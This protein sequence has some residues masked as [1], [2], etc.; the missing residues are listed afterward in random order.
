M[1]RSITVVVLCVALQLPGC[2]TNLGPRAITQTNFSYN[3]AISRSWNEQFVLN[4][5]RLRYR[6]TA[7]FLEVG[8]ILAQYELR[9]NADAT[10]TIIEGAGNVVGLGLGGFYSERPTIT[11]I[12]L[13][14]ERYVQSVLKPIP[15]V[16]LFLL[17]QSGWSIERLFLC[18]VAEANGIR[19]APSAT[20]PTPT[21]APVYKDFNRISYLL[22][23]IQMA[24]KFAVR[25]ELIEGA[26]RNEA[27]NYEPY[28]SFLPGADEA[29]V[30]EIRSLLGLPEG[31][32]EFRVVGH[33]TAERNP[34]DIVLTGRSVLGML[35]YLS[36]AVE[37]PEEDEQAGRVTVT[38]TLTGERFDWHEA[39]GGLLQIRTANEEP[40]NAYVKVQ[41]R[42][43]WFFI[44]DSDLMSKST[45]SLLLLIFSLQSAGGEPGF[46]PLLTVP[47]G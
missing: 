12:P 27:S 46:A 13:R 5:V 10:G 29:I 45:F 7:F 30:A 14:G 22:R 18:C 15:P 20:G 40:E 8:N 9:V 28:V 11:Y 1:R 24:E 33:Y 47:A 23:Q 42:D 26:S 36:Q 25:Y 16:V 39:G 19:N 31:I 6:D 41:Y 35:Y 3:E 32:G 34:E 4:L 43:H 21:R 38:R 17:S 44:E 2:V 37:A